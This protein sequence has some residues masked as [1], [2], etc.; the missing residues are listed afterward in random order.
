MIGT[1]LDPELIA[2]AKGSLVKRVQNNTEPIESVEN[3]SD[4]LPKSFQTWTVLNNRFPDE[5]RSHVRNIPVGTSAIGLCFPYNI[6]FR[7]EDIVKQEHQ[8]RMYDTITCLSV[9][10]WIHLYHG[11]DGLKQVFEKIYRALLPGG[12]F[13]LEPQPWKTYH[14]RKFTTAETAKHYDEI[15]LRPKD[16]EAYLTQQVGFRSCE[17]LEVCQTSQ[18]GFKRPLYVYTK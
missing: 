14:N 1:D 18:K 10:K 6:V 16:F 2:T 13:I 7:C 5:L 15:E 9:S 8:G 17:F 3:A 12:Q 11:D 4:A